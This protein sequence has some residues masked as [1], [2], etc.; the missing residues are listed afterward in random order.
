MKT[1]KSITKRIRVT[2]NKKLVRR[3]AGQNHFNARSTGKEGRKKHQTQN[4]HSRDVK[5]LLERI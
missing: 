5:K 4:I 3:A 1:N 2:K